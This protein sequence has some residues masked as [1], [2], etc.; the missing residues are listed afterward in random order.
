MPT[1]GLIDLVPEATEAVIRRVNVGIVLEGHCLCLHRAHQAFG[2]SI[3]RR[4]ADGGQTDV[5]AAGVEPLE[6]GGS[7]ILDALVGVLHGGLP[8]S[9]GPSPGGA[10][11]RL[12]EVTAQMPAAHGTRVDIQPHGPVHELCAQAHVRT[13]GNPAVVGAHARHALHQGGSARGGLAAGRRPRPGCRAVCLSP[14]RTP[15]ARPGFPVHWPVF[16][17]PEGRDAP[18]AIGGPVAR[19]ALA[20]GLEP[21][22]VTAARLVI[23]AAP[24]A[25]E[26][27]A[28]LAEGMALAEPL[29]DL[30][31]L[32]AGWGTMVVAVCKRS[33]SRVKRPTSRAHS[34]VRA[35]SWVGLWSGGSKM[36]ARRAR[37][38]ACQ[39]ASTD[40]VSWCSRHHSA[41]LLAPGNSSRT[42]W[43][44]NS[45]VK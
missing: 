33:C 6:I 24:R 19:A 1:L 40:A 18:R 11:A 9:Q 28:K 10:R 31:R 3:G 35:L 16:T 39:A 42:T 29:H 7:G 44:L 36:E 17:R 12:V 2:L 37:T 15:E 34:A 30:P 43:A 8:L 20:G 5:D 13:I 32:V 21:R 41:R 45:A 22:L 25:A 38:R 23:V 26:P 27:P 4:R 14:Q